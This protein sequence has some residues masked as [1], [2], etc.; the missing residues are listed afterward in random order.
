MTKTLAIIGAGAKAAAIVAR[1]AA[2][3]ALG[4]P[5]VPKIC[6]FEADHIAAAWSGKGNFSSGSLTI[7]TPPEKDVGFPYIEITPRGEIKEALSPY[8]FG[9][10]S[11][12]SYLVQRGDFDEW[13]D[14][15]REYPK[16]KDW[17]N[18][19]KYVFEKSQQDVIYA[20]VTSVKPINMV[21]RLNYTENR[22]NHT[23]DVD[24]VVLTGTGPAKSIPHSANMPQGQ[25][26]DHET[27]WPNR[28]EVLK[29]EEGAIAVAGDGGAAG[30][31]VAWLSE[32][33][34]EKPV[35]I[36][37]I[38][39]AGTLFPR[40]DGYAER[41]WFSDPSDWQ[42]LS[43]THRRKIIDRTE[44]G[45]VS[46]RNKKIIDKATNVD[47]VR[48]KAIHVEHDNGEISIKTVYEKIPSTIKANFFIS[49]IGFNV[50]ESL[51][52][53]EISKI[54]EI[55]ESTDICNQIEENITADLSLPNII[56][57]SD[58]NLVKIPDGLHIPALSGLSW[59]PGM[60]N[61]GCLGLMAKAVL[62]RYGK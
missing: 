28:E 44:S 3:R 21:W 49:A 38:S 45:V 31:I 33:L 41:R 2:L 16:H 35:T 5:D 52:M 9:M 30:A 60:S 20:R 18:Y 26:F 54:D 50:W 55:I 11:W 1:A 40:G 36:F 13:I 32:R 6:V 56:N 42:N 37:S 43:F 8:M 12:S 17:A 47:Y 22:Q 48:G 59:G 39:P 57:I 29:L 34:A 62:R 51:R 27:F 46:I 10:F 4:Q 24:G 61:L 19:L 23:M 14:R 25:F 15:G 7:C 53:F 58:K